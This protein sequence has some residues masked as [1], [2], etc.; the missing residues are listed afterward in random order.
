MLSICVSVN[1]HNNIY[2]QTEKRQKYR[3]LKKAAMKLLQTDQRWAR[4]VTS[5]SHKQ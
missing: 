3:T 2:V 5:V 4:G 1:K